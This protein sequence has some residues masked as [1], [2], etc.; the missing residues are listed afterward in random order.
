MKII[1]IAT[2]S[3]LIFNLFIT[4]LILKE[5]KRENRV[6]AEEAK[7]Y[8]YNIKLANAEKDALL[9]SETKLTTDKASYVIYK[10][11]DGDDK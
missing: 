10:T 3:I 1:C 6:K 11:A 5:L 7:R 9:K 2:L 8:T 4:L